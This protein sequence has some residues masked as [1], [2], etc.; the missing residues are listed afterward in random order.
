MRVMVLV[1]A[2]EEYENG[3]MPTRDE[4]AAMGDF[5]DELV[6]AG[7]MLDG[8]GLHPSTK[9]ARV[10]YAR[11]EA[12]SVTDGPFAE[13][14]ELVAGFWMWQVRDM[15]EA[16]EWARRIPFGGEVG[17]EGSVEIRPVFETEDFGEEMT[18]ELRQREERMRKELGNAVGERIGGGEQ[19][20]G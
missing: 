10:E 19:G 6:K 18:P 7:V 11:G 4:L 3:A 15:D 9:G 8:D 1:K 5:N 12:P 2:S 20:A 17:D 14:K 13:T 16:L